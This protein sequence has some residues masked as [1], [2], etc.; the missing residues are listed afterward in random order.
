MLSGIVVLFSLL[1]TVN[2]AQ[3]YER[4]QRQYRELANK[5]SVLSEG[6]DTVMKNMKRYEKIDRALQNLC[7]QLSEEDEEVDDDHDDDEVKSGP[8]E[9]TKKYDQTDSV[10]HNTNTQLSGGDGGGRSDSFR[11]Q[12]ADLQVTFAKVEPDQEQQSFF[13]QYSAPVKAVVR[14][15][16][17]F[18]DRIINVENRFDDGHG[19]ITVHSNQ[20]LMLTLFLPNREQVLTKMY[21][22]VNSVNESGQVDVPTLSLNTLPSVEAVFEKGSST[23]ITIR[24]VSG[25]E[26]SQPDSDYI[27]YAVNTTA[28]NTINAYNQRSRPNPVIVGARP[29]KDDSNHT[30]IIVT[31]NAD[32][33]DREGILLLRLN[34]QPIRITKFD[35][36]LGKELHIPVRRADHTA[37]FPKGYL[38]FY[39]DRFSSSIQSDFLGCAEHGSCTGSV[40]LLG[41]DPKNITIWRIVGGLKTATSLVTAMD[42][43]SLYTVRMVFRLVNASLSDTGRYVIQG[44]SVSG[45]V[46]E[47]ELLVEVRGQFSV[48]KKSSD[49][50]TNTPEK[51]VVRCLVMGYPSPEIGFYDRPWGEADRYQFVRGPGVTIRGHKSL[52]T[53]FSELTIQGPHEEIQEIYCQPETDTYSEEFLLYDSSDEDDDIADL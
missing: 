37:P 43:T 6:L 47:K 40:L 49:V 34:L 41:D 11:L 19:N 52:D 32:K 22:T 51:L 20:Y 26:G 46:I 10:L 53:S 12:D 42:V 35:L 48:V 24:Y 5:V 50:R 23:N 14:V 31:I 39:F 29:T 1:L 25:G 45:V 28:P 17:S 3:R 36:S 30:D 7:A 21:T 9:A 27:F 44:A 2:S 16:A 38:G 33:N 18:D 8:L 4:L 13:F 15:R